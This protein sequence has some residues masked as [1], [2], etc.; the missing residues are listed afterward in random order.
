MVTSGNAIEHEEFVLIALTTFRL[1]ASGQKLEDVLYL[2]YTE[3]R[4]KW[5][6]N[7][8]RLQYEWTMA[9]RRMKGRGATILHLRLELHW[10]PG[11][12][13]AMARLRQL[14]ETM[15]QDSAFHA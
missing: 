5:L 3:Q 7:K 4:Q 15:E 1:F 8:G 12:L 13:D 2:R 11:D 14:V 9:Q 6:A 10:K